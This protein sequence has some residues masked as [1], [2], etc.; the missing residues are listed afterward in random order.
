MASDLTDVDYTTYES[1]NGWMEI[2]TVSGGEQEPA[3]G[4]E[5]NVTK[6]QENQ[7]KPYIELL[8]QKDDFLALARKRINELED[9]VKTLEQRVRYLEDLQSNAD[10][11]R[12][13]L[14]DT[15][16]KDG[17]KPNEQHKK[18]PTASRR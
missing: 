2:Q 14:T 17:Q 7:Y 8:A 5:N 1:E 13:N 16:H 15:L 3:A 18:K 12:K 4:D 10:R 9:Y 11:G 6:T